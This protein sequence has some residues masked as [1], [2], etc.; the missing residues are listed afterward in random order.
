M[1]EQICTLKQILS[2]P[3]KIVIISHWRPHLAR[4]GMQEVAGDNMLT[5]GFVINK[6]YF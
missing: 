2:N 1:F 5:G 4:T 6:A 3:S